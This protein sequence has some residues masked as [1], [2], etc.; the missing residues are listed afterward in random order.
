MSESDGSTQ[1]KSHADVRHEHQD[2]PLPP[3]FENA[4]QFRAVRLANGFSLE[5]R[6]ADRYILTTI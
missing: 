4:Q 6:P 3:D 2:G 1:E 5:V